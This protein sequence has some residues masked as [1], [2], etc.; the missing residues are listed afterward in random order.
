MEGKIDSVYIPNGGIAV[1]AI[2]TEQIFE[3]YKNNPLIEALPPI[4]SKDEAIDT[5]SF[6]PERKEEERSL[7]AEYRFH[8]VQKLFQYFEPLNKHIDIE[9]RFS[10]II[11]QGYLARNPMGVDYAARLQYG[12]KGIRSGSY[13]LNKGISFRTTAAGFTII[14]ISGIGKTTTIE[15]ILIRYPQIIVHSKYKEDNLSLYQIPWLKLDCPFDGSIKGL[16]INFFNEVDKLLG[17]D[18]C[19]K[20]GLGRNTVD[21]ML[22]RMSQVASL[23]CIGV[24][25]IDEIQHLSLAKSGGS[26][27]MLNFFVTLVNT[28][29]IPVVLIGTTK[30]LPI[31][32]GEFRQARRG[33]GQGDFIWDR[34]KKDATWELFLSGM[35]PLQWT[36]KESILT[37]EIIDTI[38]DES[39]GIIDIAVKLYVLA[40][41]RAI[42]T[43]KEIVTAQLIKQ[44]AKDSLRL[45]RPMLDALRS[46]NLNS[47]SQYE[48]IIPLDID[49]FKKEQLEIVKRKNLRKNN[50]NSSGYQSLKN[51]EIITDRIILKLVE[52]GISVDNAKEYVQQVVVKGKEL[53]EVSILRDAF[54][55]SFS[56]NGSIEKKATNNKQVK[57]KVAVEEN[58]LKNI[59]EDGEKNNKSAY[60]VL[61]EKGF[62]KSPLIEFVEEDDNNI[63]FFSKS[64]S[65]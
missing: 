39:Q 54:K 56:N 28:I 5:L 14:G 50:S 45:V 61:K 48:D 24:L 12:Y 23:H 26:E 9:Q 57:T 29:G 8:C 60:Q 33:S 2:Y 58:Q 52:L 13:N 32:Q 40:Q 42:A 65:G 59:V 22:W 41:T 4:L 43:G 51:K 7:D 34:M 30:A 18:Y 10:K 16:C 46:G 47:I 20:F 3:D 64:V 19:K 25:I 55:L 1:N 37:E 44:V 11:R 62:I 53:D 63:K 35:W 6:V 27:R 17:T 49:E 36:K 21:S 38:Y 15:N 31:L